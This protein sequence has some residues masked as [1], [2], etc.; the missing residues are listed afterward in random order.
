MPAESNSPAWYLESF[1]NDSK[2]LWRFPLL[3]FP[4]PVGRHIERGLSLLSPLISH[5]HAEI[6]VDG[7]ALK[8]RDL[9]STNGTYVNGVRIAEGGV[10][11]LNEGDI[12]HFA[13]TEFRLGLLAPGETFA[14]SETRT[15]L[16]L[17][18]PQ[19][20]VERARRLS[21]LLREGAVV[22]NIQPVVRLQSGEVMG[23]EL[24]G[25]GTADELPKSPKELFD[26]AATLGVAAELSRLFRIASAPLLRGLPGQPVLFFNTHPAELEKPGLVASLHA[27]REA[28]P[29]ERLALEIHEQAV[30]SPDMIRELRSTLADLKIELA[31]DDFGAGRGRINELVEV[32]PE[33]LKFDESLIRGI[34]QAPESKRDLMRALLRVCQDGNIQTLAEGVETEAE[35]QALRD[36]GFDLVQGYLFGRPAPIDAQAYPSL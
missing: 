36:L 34:D 11:A 22:S 16:N 7:G 31:Y 24:L 9:G 3:R 15:A 18:I 27:L 20:L 25:R 13:T 30:T 23:Y 14:L 28:L 29:K 32:P 5:N 10:T 2:S 33:Y 21:G 8:V 4:M 35:A 17:E 1:A 12:L 19:Q 6:Y 26:L